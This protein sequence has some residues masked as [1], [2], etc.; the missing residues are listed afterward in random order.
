MNSFVLLPDGPDRAADELADGNDFDG[1]TMPVDGVSSVIEGATANELL[2][3]RYE[4]PQLWFFRP[5]CLAFDEI[6]FSCCTS[7]GCCLVDVT[8]LITAPSV[9]NFRNLFDLSLS[10]FRAS[11][12][13]L[14]AS[15]VR[16]VGEVLWC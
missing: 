14:A 4:Q 7:L 2:P 8:S 5:L 12:S 16:I 9:S 13:I 11:L 10:K 15:P 6:S 1:S 3:S